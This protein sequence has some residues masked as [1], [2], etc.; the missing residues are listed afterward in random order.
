MI[1]P[2]TCPICEKPLPPNAGTELPTFPFCGER[3]RLVDLSRWSEG[4][5]TI[6][7]PLDPSR[8]DPELLDPEA[9]DPDADPPSCGEWGASAP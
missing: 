9:F 5:Y 8:L 3:C 4:K 1:R 2:Q 6:V 7:E